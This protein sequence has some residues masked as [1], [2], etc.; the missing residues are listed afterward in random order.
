MLAGMVAFAHGEVDIDTLTGEEWT[1]AHAAA[2]Q[3]DFEEWKKEGGKS[4]SEAPERFLEHAV[5]GEQADLIERMMSGDRLEKTEIRPEG[6]ATERVVIVH[7]SCPA[8][9][10]GPGKHEWQNFTP[11]WRRITK[12]RFEIWTPLQG[13]LFDGKG[14]RVATATVRRGD[15]YGREWYG[16]FLP[17]GRW[18]TADLDER[19]DTLAL[20]SAKGKRIAAIK[21]DTL[22]PAKQDADAYNGAPL[23]AWARSDR[24]GKA[25]IVSVGSEFGRGWVKVTPD[26]KWSSVENP[27]KECFPQQ[28][29]PRGMYTNKFVYS[30][31]GATQISRME[32]GHGVWVSWPRYNFHGVTASVLVP[33]GEKF[34]IL[35]TGWATFV[36]SDASELIPTEANRQHERY[37][38][39]DQQGTFSHWLKG[40]YVG[41]DLATGG[42]W[43]RMPDDTCVR[44]GKDFTVKSHLRFRTKEGAALS[45]VELHEDI[46]L[47]LFLMG[48]Q[49]ALGTWQTEET[50]KP[51]QSSGTG[52]K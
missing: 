50:K 45:A 18:V 36:Q 46:R 17:D 7:D 13:K 39:F 15:G 44:V 12:D 34:G 32:P 28:L 41:T 5:K 3:R 27:W 30:D 49:L 37:W 43:V 33:G 38:M 48:D 25:W 23:I 42:P 4:Q 21:G 22:I 29:G 24:T 47:G 11:V 9:E 10:K 19:D 51:S 40:R 31:D 26:G 14:N 8:A 2:A 52:K 20:F 16:A 6:T 35:P 1:Q